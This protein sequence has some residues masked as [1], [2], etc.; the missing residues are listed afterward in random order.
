MAL[1]D[2]MSD[3]G[4][5]P[6]RLLL[7]S[8]LTGAALLGGVTACSSDGDDDATTTTTTAEATTTTEAAADETGT[9]NEDLD[10]YCESVT[11]LEAEFDA[12]GTVEPD[13]YDGLL[14]ASEAIAEDPTVQGDED[15][16]AAA[17]ECLTA[18]SE[19]PFGEGGEASAEE[20]AAAVCADSEALVAQF[21]QVADVDAYVAL[22]E[23]ATA[24]A[25]A[26]ASVVEEFPDQVETISLCNE[27]VT[28]AANQA[29][30]RLPVDTP[31]D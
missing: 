30:S 28:D 31:T 25:A 4:I 27:A 16:A 3:V 19:I 7:V 5:R 14:V 17:E 26:G 29:A 18:F 10:T 12:T 1:S 23:E 22:E 9:G 15:L 6:A 24:V 21:E 11:E 2:E 20:Q 8:L 13:T